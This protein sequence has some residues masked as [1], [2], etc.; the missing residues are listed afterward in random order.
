MRS[1][2]AFTLTVCVCFAR[3]RSLSLNR[4]AGVVP[5]LQVVR[6]FGKDILEKVPGL[7]LPRTLLLSAIIAAF[8]AQ[9]RHGDPGHRRTGVV[10]A[11]Q[12]GCYHVYYKNI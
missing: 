7:P 4:N 3:I 8:H 10:A 5:T 6:F 9:V 11:F 12:M 2:S 1:L